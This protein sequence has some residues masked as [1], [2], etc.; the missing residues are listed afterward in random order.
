MQETG[1]NQRMITIQ[2]LNP[3][4]TC[5][6]ASRLL[7]GKGKWDIH[8]SELEVRIYLQDS[9]LPQLVK[10]VLIPIL[11]LGIE[12]TGQS[13][14]GTG[15][16]LWNVWKDDFRFTE[17][18]MSEEFIA[19]MDEEITAYFKSENVMDVEQWAKGQKQFNQTLSS[20][21]Q[22]LIQ[23]GH[24]AKKLEACGWV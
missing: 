10:D 16:S 5:R 15:N 11:K 6:L 22:D 13:R 4:W 1:T 8:W 2:S 23:E 9:H 3:E 12:T 18:L 19:Q 17:M 20:I 21:E 24:V 14:Y 7:V